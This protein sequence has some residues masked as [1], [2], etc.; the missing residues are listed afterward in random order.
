MSLLLAFVF[1]AVLKLQLLAPGLQPYVHDGERATYTIPNLFWPN[2]KIELELRPDPDTGARVWM[3][4]G[5]HGFYP[6]FQHSIYDD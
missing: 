3:T 5:S 6:F 4:E 2:E 1:Y